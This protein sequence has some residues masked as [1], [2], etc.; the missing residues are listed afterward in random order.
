MHK[1]V[2]MAVLFPPPLQQRGIIFVFSCS[3]MRKT[4]EV[5]HVMVSLF[6]W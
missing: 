6:S 1:S 2:Q 3:L 4:D 5:K